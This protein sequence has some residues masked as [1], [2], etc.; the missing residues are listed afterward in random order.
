M[1]HITP[2]TST[3][4]PSDGTTPPHL[5]VLV[6]DDEEFNRELLT[7]L[8]TELDWTVINAA[9]GYEAIECFQKHQP[10]IVLMDVL[11]PGMDGYEA[12]RAIKQMAGNQHVP[13]I[14]VTSLSDSEA[15]SRCLDC[16]GDDFLS[17]SCNHVILYAKLA[18]H[19]RIRRQTLTLDANNRVLARHTDR[20]AIEHT[21]A[22]RVFD[23]RNPKAPHASRPSSYV[24]TRVQPANN[25]PPVGMWRPRPADRPVH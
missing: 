13:V 19:S 24:P 20:I 12:T 11:M 17:K 15:H 1:T 23:H 18:A 10:D 3:T 9:D 21:L 8:L 22:G 5:T 25:P 14:F 6:V 7:M 2:A 16:G 4:S